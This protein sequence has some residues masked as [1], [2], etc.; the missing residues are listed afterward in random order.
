MPVKSCQKKASGVVKRL[1]RECQE[2]SRVV[3][4]ALVSRVVKMMSR[5]VKSRGCQ[6]VVKMMSRACQEL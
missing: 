6:E 2:E 3:K 5:V 4:R 1:S